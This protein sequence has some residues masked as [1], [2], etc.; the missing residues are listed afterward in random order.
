MIL[1]EDK[2]FG[3]GKRRS[4][5]WDLNLVELKTNISVLVK[6]YHQIGISGWRSWRQGFWF[7]LMGIARLESQVDQA[8]DKDFDFS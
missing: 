6:A 2:D 8:E 5:D 7:W 4:P 3:Y 1:L